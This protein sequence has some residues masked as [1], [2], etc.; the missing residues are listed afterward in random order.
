MY[1]HSL[2]PNIIPKKNKKKKQVNKSLKNAFILKEIR[3][4]IGTPSFKLKFSLFFV[5]LRINREDA[6]LI[7]LN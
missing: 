7:D 1:F 5:L 3:S 6:A 2:L 4:L